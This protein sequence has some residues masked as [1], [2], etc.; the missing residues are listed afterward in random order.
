MTKKEAE[1]QLK[2]DLAKYPDWYCPLINGMCQSNCVC[3]QKAYIIHND[4]DKEIWYLRKGRCF[5]V[6][7]FGNNQ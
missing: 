5:N 3:Y 7:F 4:C 6:M 1:K 2:R